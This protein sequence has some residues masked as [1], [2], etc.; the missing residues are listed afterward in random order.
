MKTEEEVDSWY[1]ET[2]QLIHDEYLKNLETGMPSTEAE[3]T[4][5]KK[6]NET[7]QQYKE[8]MEEIFHKRLHPSKITILYR[9][10][11]QKI[12]EFKKKKE[13]AQK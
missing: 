9:K 7:Q 8:Q 4:Y 2:K 13:E 6:F 10:A 12:K 5:T 3:Q 11:K 1:E